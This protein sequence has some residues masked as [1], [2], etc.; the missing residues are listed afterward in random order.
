MSQPTYSSETP[1][2][3]PKRIAAVA[4]ASTKGGAAR[5]VTNSAASTLLRQ[6]VQVLTDPRLPGFECTLELITPE[7]AEFYLSKLPN[8]Q[9]RIQQR[10]LSTKSVDRYSEDMASEQWL[11]IADVIRFNTIGELVDGQHRLRSIIQAGTSEF[12]LV[13]RGLEPEAFAVFDTGR[14][15]SFTDALR[16]LGVSNVSMAAGTTRRVFHWRRGNYGVAN[17]ARVPNPQFLGVPAS[18]GKLLET[19]HEMRQEIQQA[20]RRGGA[21][22]AQFATKTAAP[23][24]VA[25][26]YLLFSRLDL[27]RCEA[28]F[29]ELQIGPAQVG[30]EYPIAVLRDRLMR[31]VK[32][33]EQ[34]SPDWVWIHFFITTWNKWYE[35]KSMGPLKTPP[36]STIQWIAKPVDP[37][38]ATRP[39]GWEPLGGVSA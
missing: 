8:S 9:S 17:V 28:F 27:D 2:A 22:K 15:R 26:I 16:S 11:F 18:P 30:P 19:F 1:R 4:A 23:A 25:F 6:P 36:R 39:E 34:A 29:H 35:A 31:Q 12:Q 37:N 13:A 14:A 3:N 32:A 24:V 7:T 20:G 10:S 33:G 21:L 38:A 5:K